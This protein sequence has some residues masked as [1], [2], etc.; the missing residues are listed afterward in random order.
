MTKTSIEWTDMV[1]NPV[2]GCSKVSAGCKNCYAERIHGRFVRRP[3]TEVLCHDERLDQPLGW[4]KQRRVFVNSMSDLFHE[5]VPDEFIASVFLTMALSQL[6]TFQILTKRPKR[7]LDW[8]SDPAMRATII[9]PKDKRADW[10]ATDPLNSFPWPLPNVWLGVSVE[11]QTTA[12]ER[13][14]I[15]LQTP[16]VLRFASLEPLLSGIDLDPRWIGWINVG[17]DHGQGKSLI[18]HHTQIAPFLNGRKID[19]LNWLICGGES[20]PK[21]RPM[22]PDWVRSVRDQCQSA[23]VPFFF[24][25]W[26]EW[27]RREDHPEIS[28][29]DSYRNRPKMI[30]VRPDGKDEMAELG[31]NWTPMIKVGKKIA[32]RKLDG[33]EWNDFPFV[34][35]GP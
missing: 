1:W 14:P 16:A 4:K 17:Y 28:E 21:A 24:K 19:Q 27:C 8:C 32:G 3:F 29:Y 9:E 13:I 25:Q 35:A 26:G 11:D 33:R 15:L 18:A 2:T 5:A 22:H 30:C 12:D 20:G 34:S 23:K 7:M 31:S 6:H 10:I